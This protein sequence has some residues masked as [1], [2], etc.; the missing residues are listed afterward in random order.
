MKPFEKIIE[1]INEEELKPTPRWHFLLKNKVLWIVFG[2]ASLL[3]ALAFSVILFAIQQTDF[4]LINHLS[5]SGLELFLGLLPFLWIGFLVVFLLIAMYSVQY[6]NR[7]YK[8]SLA[9][10]TGYSAALSILI[11][12]LF[13]I[14]GGAKGLENAFAANVSFYESMQE[15]KVKLWSMPDDGFL[16]GEIIGTELKSFQLKDFSGDEWQINYEGAFVPPVVL[17]ERGEIVKL[18]GDKTSDQSFKASEVRPWGGIGRMQG[19]GRGNQN[20]NK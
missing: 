13:F 19:K 1:K 4:E 15:K 11:G 3:G 16:S 17:I 7:G 18:V 12:T 10:L 14:A 8:F 20:R 2:I 5:H 6:S 9:S